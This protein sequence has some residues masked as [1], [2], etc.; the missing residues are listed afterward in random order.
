MYLMVFLRQRRMTQSSAHPPCCVRA[1]RL[2]KQHKDPEHIQAF[3]HVLELD[4]CFG[5]RQTG[6]IVIER[7]CSHASSRRRADPSD[8]FIHARRPASKRPCTSAGGNSFMAY[9]AARLLSALSL[10]HSPTPSGQTAAVSHVLSYAPRGGKPWR[11]HRSPMSVL[12]VVCTL[13]CFPFGLSLM[14]LSL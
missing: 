13:L 10:R 9:L 6:D 11:Q 1:Q 4:A 8:A 5:R 3:V 12:A 2:M 14:R 7:S